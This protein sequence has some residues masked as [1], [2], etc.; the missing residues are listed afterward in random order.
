M[1]LKDQSKVTEPGIRGFVERIVGLK[2]SKGKREE[3]KIKGGGKRMNEKDVR[4]ERKFE[5][6]VTVGRYTVNKWR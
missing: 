1:G 3:N 6:K 2:V 5:W 4:R